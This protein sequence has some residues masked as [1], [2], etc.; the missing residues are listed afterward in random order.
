MYYLWQSCRRCIGKWIWQW[1]DKVLMFTRMN[2]LFTVLNLVNLKIKWRVSQI[3]ST[4]TN[5]K[6][7]LRSSLRL[8]LQRPNDLLHL[9]LL[10]PGYLFTVV[11]EVLLSLNAVNL[12]LQVHL[13]LLMLCSHTTTKYLLKAF[14]TKTTKKSAKR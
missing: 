5:N 11:A 3:K 4:L 8:F 1:F 2:L 10:T 13:L 14:S 9:L 12:L 7:S 6:R